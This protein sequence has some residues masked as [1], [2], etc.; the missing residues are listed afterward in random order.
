MT[1]LVAIPGSYAVSRLNFFGRRQISSLFL[2]VYLF[3][4]ILIAIPL[5]VGF[6]AIGIRESLFG[7]VIV[8]IAQTIPI[9]IYMLR[10]YLRTIPV[11]VE[12]AAMVDGAA[13]FRI[14]RSV[15]VPLG[16]AVDHVDRPVR[17]HDRLERVPVRAAVPHRATA[18]C[19]RCRWGCRSSRTASRCPRR[20]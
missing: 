6:S 17:L 18:T 4:S 11:S 13:R 20:C 8:Y 10:T 9:S 12:E 2:A 16:A 14:L 3:P 19:G 5:F 1:L 7:L 15:T